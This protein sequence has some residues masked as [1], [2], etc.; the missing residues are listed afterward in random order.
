MRSLAAAVTLLAAL[1]SA[2]AVAQEDIRQAPSCPLCGMDRERFA[3]TRMVIRYEDGS[4]TGVCSLHC[5]AIELAVHFDRPVK[6]IEVGDAATRKLLDAEQATWVVG[7]TRPGV[8]SRRGKWAFETRAAAEAFARENGGE[9]ATFEAALEAAYQDLYGDL[10]M[11]REKRK[12]RGHGGAKP[13]G[14]HQH[15]Q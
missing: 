9:L 11:L 7:G 4:S 2:P 1:S 13:H 6:A 8:M 10:K 3:Q 5:A 15:Q 12:A 14:D